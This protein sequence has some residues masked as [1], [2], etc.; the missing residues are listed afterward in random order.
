MNAERLLQHYEKTADAS[1]A[2]I[3]LRRFILDLAVRGKLVPQDSA[4][5]PASELLKRIAAEKA[6]LVKAGEIR[7]PKA[8]PPV[9]KSPFELPQSWRWARIREITSDRGQ[10]VPE[11]AF[12]YIDVT[13]INKE[14]GVVADPKVL[15]PSEAPGRAR[16]LVM[17]GDVLY[18]CVRPYLL[19]VAIIDTEFVPKPIASTA[20]AVLNGHGLVA[21]RYIWIVLRSPF[22]VEC[23]EETQRGLAYPAI[24]DADFAV[25]PFPLPPLSE[26]HRIVAKVDEL[27]ELCDQLEAARTARE[28]TRDRLAAAS[29]ARLDS[30]DPETFRDDARFALG[31]L[32]A[33][34]ARPDQIKQLRQAILNLA[35]RG[36]LVPQ[37]PKDEPAEDLLKRIAREKARLVKSGEIRKERELP[38]LSDADM[39]FELP[40]HWAWARLGDLTQLVTSGSRDWAKYYSSEGAIFVRMGN[41]SKDHYRLRLD[42]IQRVKPPGDG[43]GTRTRLEAGDILIS[44]TGDV[45]MLGLIPE[46]F[47]EAYINQHTAMVRPAPQM[48]GRYLAE[49]FR[50]PF[51][52]QQFNEPQRGIKNS[53]RLTDITQFVVPLPPLAEQHRI[54]AK[55]DE[56]MA[57][58][59]Q[60]EASLIT[61][62]ETRRKL[63]DALLAEAVTS[64]ALESREAAE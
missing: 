62:D 42:Q 35:V 32:P 26:Q 64:S 33:L 43:E 18:S 47:G 57:L 53:F 50:S 1:D 41:L 51:A 23:V 49:L 45:G 31:T 17:Q 55:V 9:E 8:L 3:R 7:K 19:N 40:Y 59:G 2:I 61:A 14:A 13:A 10:E 5:E 38:S 4:D 34:T 48:K 30:P 46:G 21:P 44:I 12:T 39:S 58:C 27:M 56:L 6:R 60:L 24:N 11:A 16:K 25:L 29:L 20:F 52:Q 22:M 15:Q 63:L 54:V 37:D 28:A 36:K